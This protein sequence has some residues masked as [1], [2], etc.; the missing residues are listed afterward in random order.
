MRET[1]KKDRGVNT[2][3]GGEMRE[4]EAKER[5]LIE[6]ILSERWESS[7]RRNNGCRSYDTDTK[8]HDGKTMEKP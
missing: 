6:C 1:L 4:R 7:L 8:A 3:V 5:T 2:E